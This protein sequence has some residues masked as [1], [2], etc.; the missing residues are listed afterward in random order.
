VEL[1]TV[2][3][4]E[5]VRPNARKHSAEGARIVPI[6]A[7]RN[8]TPTGRVCNGDIELVSIPDEHGAGL[9][10]KWSQF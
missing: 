8:E 3:V 5:A 10:R 4:V 2:D 6:I 1:Q 7:I 9:F